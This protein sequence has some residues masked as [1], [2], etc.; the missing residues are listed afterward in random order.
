MKS[1][2]PEGGSQENTMIKLFELY[3]ALLEPEVQLSHSN[4]TKN[5][6]C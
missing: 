3:F 6:F 2:L 1:V 5:H 4:I